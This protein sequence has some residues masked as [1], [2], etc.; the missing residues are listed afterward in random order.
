MQHVRGRL[1]GGC[2]R[3]LRDRLQRGLVRCLRC[4]LLRRELHRVPELQNAAVNAIQH[5]RDKL[6]EHKN[7]IHRHGQDMPE[8]REWEWPY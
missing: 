6:V 2:L 4:R 7:Y 1:H 8:I 3:H 5:V